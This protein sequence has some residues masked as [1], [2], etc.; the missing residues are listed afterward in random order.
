MGTG[1]Q[2]TDETWNPL[3]GCTKVS[4]GCKNCYALAMSNRLR[5]MGVENYRNGFELTLHPH[6]LDKPRRWK[7]PRRIFVN[8]MSDLFHENVPRDYI[9]RVFQVI[10]ECPRHQFQILTKR[11]DI[12]FEFCRAERLQV[13]R[14][15]W[16]GVSVEN[17]DYLRRVDDLRAIDCDHRFLSLE[18]LLGPMHGELVLDGIK[19]VIVGGESGPKHRPPEK[20][21]ILGLRNLCSRELVGFTFKQWG[22]INPKAGGRELDGRVH[23]YNPMDLWAGR[24]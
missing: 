6:T 11:S 19:W 8:S 9:R 4:P 14:N 5:A 2:W 7:K 22:G 15:A 16:L 1:I 21:W 24:S 10:E 13:P 17:R 18:P 3:T 20:E 12:M 23:D